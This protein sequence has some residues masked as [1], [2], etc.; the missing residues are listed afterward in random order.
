MDE[1]KKKKLE[2]I[3]YQVFKCCG[4]CKHAEFKNSSKFGDCLK[5]EYKHQ[6]HVAP[7]KNLSISAFGGCSDFELEETSGVMLHRFVDFLK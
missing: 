2:S 7:S 5:N 3:G 4:L 1:S 6:K